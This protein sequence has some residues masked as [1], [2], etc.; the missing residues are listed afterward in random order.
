MGSQERD[1]DEHHELLR[2]T[3]GTNPRRRRRAAEGHLLAGEVCAGRSKKSVAKFESQPLEH[4]EDE[5][6]D[7]PY[8][9]LVDLGHP[10]SVRLSNLRLVAPRTARADVH[11]LMRSSLS[12]AFDRLYTKHR[13]SF[14]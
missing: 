6:A 14:G 7:Q 10:Y 1:G 3:A 11:G 8:H 2:S 13:A 4:F 5:V 12:K 9:L